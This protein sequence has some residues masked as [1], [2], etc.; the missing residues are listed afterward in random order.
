MLKTAGRQQ[1][2]GCLQQQGGNNSRDAYNSREATTA[3]KPKAARMPTIGAQQQELQRSEQQKNYINRRAEGNKREH[4][5]TPTA[6]R[7]IRWKQHKQ[8]GF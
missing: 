7:K 3:E 4:Q 5:G 1:Q 8:K 6:G 2:Q